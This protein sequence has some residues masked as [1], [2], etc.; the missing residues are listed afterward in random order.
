MTRKIGRLFPADRRYPKRNAHGESRYFFSAT[1][2]QSSSV[3]KQGAYFFFATN[4]KPALLRIKASISF[5]LIN[6]PNKPPTEPTAPLFPL[7]NSPH[8]HIIMINSF[9]RETND[10]TSDKAVRQ[11]QRQR[12]RP[13]REG[14]LRRAGRNNGN[15]IEFAF[16]CGEADGGAFGPRPS[17]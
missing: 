17:R 8:G 9:L 16:V 6:I 11:G 12:H 13:R 4:P 15:F 1:I 3:T 7:T 5:P 14:P 2:S 10:K